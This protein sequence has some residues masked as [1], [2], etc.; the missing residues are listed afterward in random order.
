MFRYVARYV[1]HASV[2]L[3]TFFLQKLWSVEFMLISLMVPRI[4]NFKY[5]CLSLSENLDFQ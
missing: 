3:L 1:V 2:T 4:C 5:I